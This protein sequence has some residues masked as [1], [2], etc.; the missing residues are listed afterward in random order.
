MT[1]ELAELP[2]P[3]SWPA[4]LRHPSRRPNGFG[5][6]HAHPRGVLRLK[7]WKFRNGPA[8]ETEN[9]VPPKGLLDSEM[10]KIRVLC[11]TDHY[12]PGNKAGGPIRSI[13]NMSDLLAKEVD[14]SIVTRDRDLGD[15]APF[16]SVDVNEWK[17]VGTS[18]VY[19]ACP[20]TF[21]APAVEQTFDQHDVLYLNSF[22][23][24]RGSVWPYLRF[25]NRAQVLIAPR[26]EFSKGALG[27]KELK[28]KM[29]LK[30]VTLLGLYRD[31][32]WHASSALEAADI[33]RVFSCAKGNIHLAIDPVVSGPSAPSVSGPGKSDELRLVFISRISPKKN[34]DGLLSYLVNVRRALVLTIYGPI[35]DRDYWARCQSTIEK[36][37]KHIRVIYAGVLKADD[38][39]TKFSEHDLFAFPTHGENFGHV[40][41]ES[42]RVGTPVLLSDQTPW[43]VDESGAVTVVSLDSPDMWSTQIEIA[44]GRTEQERRKVRALAVR[45]AHNY[46][47]DGDTALDNLRMFESIAKG[48]SQA[49]AA[50]CP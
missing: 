45:Y 19:Y 48:D 40:I 14:F 23:S 37:P 34:L 50:R 47:V 36:L 13:A 6:V 17:R 30:L 38:V 32:Q 7:L 15:D 4:S 41:F 29:F 33:E 28:K 39:S 26:G 12:L 42:L 9:H 11:V 2:L 22:F 8:T 25:R 24:M 18:P 1:S 27:L 3:Q 49:A 46:V 10:T 20:K 21:G 35:E 5:Q 16:E 31:V 44:A 43:E